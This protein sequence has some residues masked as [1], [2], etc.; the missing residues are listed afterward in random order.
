[1]LSVK[2]S[3]PEFAK[4]VCCQLSC[5]SVHSLL[6]LDHILISTNILI[7]LDHGGTR[8]WASQK[9]T[10]MPSGY[11]I[12]MIICDIAFVLLISTLWAGHS[13]DRIL[14]WDQISAAACLWGKLW[15]HYYL[16]VIFTYEENTSYLSSNYHR[17]E[18]CWLR[19]WLR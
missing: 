18:R 17:R 14:G 5:W 12:S 16:L 8:K 13:K 2:H 6:Y 15:H 19:C 9:H 7:Y 4:I 1:M 10:Q 3:T 11:V